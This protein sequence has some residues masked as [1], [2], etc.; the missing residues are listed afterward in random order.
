MIDLD[1]EIHPNRVTEKSDNDGYTR[2]HG[3]LL[4]QVRE[5]FNS[6]Q[7]QQLIPAVPS[8]VMYIMYYD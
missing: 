2:A 8:D 6:C 3:M 4:S 5:A 7:V 1:S